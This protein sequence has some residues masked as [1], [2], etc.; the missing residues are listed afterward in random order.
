MHTHRSGLTKCTVLVIFPREGMEST[1]S[2][3]GGCFYGPK[4]WWFRVEK[5]LARR[6][7]SRACLV[8][9]E[10]GRRGVNFELRTSALP[11]T[12]LGSSGAH[13]AYLNLDVHI[14]KNGMKVARRVWVGVAWGASFS[15][16]ATLASPLRSCGRSPLPP[17][18]RPSGDF[19]RA[20]PDLRS[21]SITPRMLRSSLTVHVRQRAWQGETPVRDLRS[22][23]TPASVW[24]SP[25][26]RRKASG[27]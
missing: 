7:Q 13:L 24:V 20:L 19:P 21:P 14:P 17:K 27:V 18:R 4:S 3:G 15:P 5:K 16:L 23:K 11:L 26:N 22:D 12:L 6:A 8:G 9:G 2:G 1:E 25:W 10:L